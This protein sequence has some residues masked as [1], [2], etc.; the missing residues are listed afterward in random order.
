M[1][2]TSTFRDPYDCADTTIGKPNSNKNKIKRFIKSPLL[3][4]RRMVMATTNQQS[5]RLVDFGL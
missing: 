4:T 3:P 5:S 1:P 2:L